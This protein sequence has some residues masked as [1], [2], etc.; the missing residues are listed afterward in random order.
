VTAH[1]SPLPAMR[2][3]HANLLR[4]A[5]ARREVA[6]ILAATAPGV[7]ASAVRVAAQYAHAAAEILKDIRWQ[8][9]HT[10]VR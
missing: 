9:G 4:Q 8:E 6:A 7:S 1:P 10:H 5:R 2:R 3:H